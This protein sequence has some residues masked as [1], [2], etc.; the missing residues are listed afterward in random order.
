MRL[1]RTI[2]LCG[3]AS[4]VASAANADT[5]NF[6]QFGGLGDTVANTVTGTTGDGVGF[7]M[8]GPGDGF[9]QYVQ[10]DWG[11]GSNRWEGN[12]PTGTPVLFDGYTSGPVTITFDNA[13]TS[14]TQLAMEANAYGA[15][16]GT[17]VAYLGGVQVGT[18]SYDAVTAYD[19]GTVPSFN[20]FLAGGFDEIVL[21]TTDDFDGLGLGGAGGRGG[22]AGDV[23]EPATW[24]MMLG[25]LALAGGAMRRRRTSVA[26][27]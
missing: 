16:T 15:Y 26:F 11:D 9:T 21:S 20:F 4:L 10:G 7:T 12:F 6:S 8:V 13:I 25:G 22:Y 5:I 27:A 19:P 2:L 18:Q 3:A 24:A 1:F 23:P 17:L 14:I